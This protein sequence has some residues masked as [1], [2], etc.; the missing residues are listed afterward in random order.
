MMRR[1]TFRF[2]HLPCFVRLIE[3]V[4]PLLAKCLAGVSSD[5]ENTMIKIIEKRALTLVTATLLCISL[6]GGAHAA[7][8]GVSRDA[9]HTQA[10]HERTAKVTGN[11]VQVSAQPSEAVFALSRV[12]GNAHV[13]P[14]RAVSGGGAQTGSQ[15]GTGGEA[16]HGA[17][18][19]AGL[20]M[21]GVVASK[22]LMR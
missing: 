17:L 21:V 10:D 5:R 19:L 6:G 20:L 12:N 2:K 13:I 11:A 22:R 3:G 14:A 18:V 4:G 8:P 15:V 1:E 16:E 9:M 7:E